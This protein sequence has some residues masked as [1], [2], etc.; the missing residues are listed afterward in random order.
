MPRLSDYDALDRSTTTARLTQFLFEFVTANQP[1]LEPGSLGPKTAMLNMSENL[2]FF[3]TAFV[4]Q[5]RKYYFCS[6]LQT[7]KSAD[8]SFPFL[9]PIILM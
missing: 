5:R 7:K 1:E 8:S 9:S 2:Q 3:R 4:Y 6:F